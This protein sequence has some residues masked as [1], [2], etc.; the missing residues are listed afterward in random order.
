VWAEKRREL[1]VRDLGYHVV[2]LTWADL[3]PENAERTAARLRRELARAQR[4]Y[5]HLSVGSSGAS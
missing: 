3:A 1:K 5:G 4:L 2:R